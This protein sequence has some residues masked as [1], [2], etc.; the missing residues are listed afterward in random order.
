MSEAYLSYNYKMLNFLL[1]DLMPWHHEIYDFSTLEVNRCVNMHSNIRRTYIW[2]GRVPMGQEL[3]NLPC[4]V[5]E[6][7]YW[8]PTIP[9]LSH[10]PPPI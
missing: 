9:M 10:T 3:F 1:D 4:L 2:V 8:I 6:L 5:P 7:A